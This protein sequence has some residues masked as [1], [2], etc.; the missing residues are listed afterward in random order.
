[1]VKRI[2]G[3]L[4]GVR[5]WYQRRRRRT[6][7]L[8]AALP[9]VILIGLGWWGLRNMALR[10]ADHMT[11]T[12]TRLS[13]DDGGP[14]GGLVWRYTFGRKQASQAQDLINN[15]TV[16]RGPFS[17]LGGVVPV[18][19]GHWAYHLAF[20]WHGILIETAYVR[21]DMAP[22]FYSLSSLGIPDLDA[23]WAVSSSL[24]ASI[25]PENG[26]SIPLPPDYNPQYGAWH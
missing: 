14:T 5:G 21:L 11:V 16:A 23:H 18:P 15:H 8:L 25:S 9:L 22:E 1:M 20:T 12:I 19:G 13:A 24:L 6:R 4:P 26:V 2:T 7:L 3:R 10:S 17:R